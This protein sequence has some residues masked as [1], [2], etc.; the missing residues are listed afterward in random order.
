MNP[1]SRYKYRSKCEVSK[2]ESERESWYNTVHDSVYFT[3]SGS[4]L[5]YTQF[6][7]FL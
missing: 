5:D 3:L 4:V 1:E 2:W 6:S 7:C